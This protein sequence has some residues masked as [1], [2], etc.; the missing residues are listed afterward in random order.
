M[1][2]ELR[3]TNKDLVKDNSILM[4]ENTTLRRL[5]TEIKKKNAC[6]SRKSSISII[7]DLCDEIATLKVEIK[8]VQAKLQTYVVDS[9]REAKAKKKVYK[10]VLIISC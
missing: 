5:L 6:L 1:I 10:Y 9:R 2:I 4:N 3:N 8:V 7:D